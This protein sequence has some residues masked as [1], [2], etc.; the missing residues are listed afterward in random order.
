M[1]TKFKYQDYTDFKAPAEFEKLIYT[2]QFS[3]ETSGAVRR[4]AWFM[5][6]HMTK[7]VKAVIE[8]LPAVIDPSKI[9]LSCK[10][11]T[12]CKICIFSR[13]YTAEDKAELLAVINNKKR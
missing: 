11:K 5:E 1:C 6:T 3:A 9:C 13:Q 7:A 4:L 8:A 10:D 2:P 12:E